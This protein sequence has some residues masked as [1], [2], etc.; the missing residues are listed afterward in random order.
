MAE[1]PLNMSM[2]SLKFKTKFKTK[3]FDITTEIN[4]LKKDVKI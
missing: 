1:R 2:N 4:K 3:L